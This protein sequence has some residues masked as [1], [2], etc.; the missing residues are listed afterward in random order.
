M[1]ALILAGGTGKRLW[2]VSR[3][4]NPK[5][6]KPLL[7]EKSLVKTTYD[8]IRKGFKSE[9]IF[10]SL[11]AEQRPGIIA[12]LGKSVIKNLIIEPEKKG[13]AAAIGLACARFKADDIIVTVNSDQF[14]NN[15]REY[16][17]VLKQAEAS[18]KTYPEHLI[19]IGLKPSYPETGY[20]YIKLG[21]SIDKIGSDKLFEISAFKEKPNLPTAKRYFKSGDYLWNPAYFVFKAGTML[22]LFKKH[23]PAQARIFSEIKRQPSKLK[24][25][26]KKI[27]KISID[28]GIMEKADKMLCLPAA[29]DWVDVG[30]WQTIYQIASGNGSKNVS[31]GKYVNVDSSGNLVYSYSGKLMATIGIKDSI[32]VETEDAVLVCPKNR[33]QEV[34]QI[35]EELE[36][37]G[38]EKYL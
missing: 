30:S 15:I 28:Y 3:R 23:L 1:K 12:E 4:N 9:D 21:R 27:K 17:R 32:I 31:Q 8:R 29:F 36:K 35:V 24:S 20:G 26:F 33:S 34:K 22:E 10:I 25:E 14:V 5:Q 11:N 16:L 38:W 6:F 13:T 19:L 18:V 37:K 7:G 2:P